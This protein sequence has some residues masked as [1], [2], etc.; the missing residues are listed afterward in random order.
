VNLDTAGSDLARTSERELA[1]G[2]FAGVDFK[3][4]QRWKPSTSGP[5]EASV[6]GSE[7]AR[8]LLAAVFALLLVETLMAWRFSYGFAALTLLAVSVF[9][10]QAVSHSRTGAWIATVF[11]A[12]ILIAWIVRMRRQR[13]EQGRPPLSAR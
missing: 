2:L 7:L 6:Q 4:R 5:A 1:A 13:G 12:V 10:S 11:A 3:F 9:T 8:W